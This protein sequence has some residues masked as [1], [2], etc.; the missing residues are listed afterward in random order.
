[1]L[2]GSGVTDV[3]LMAVLAFF[4]DSEGDVAG[5]AAV[6]LRFTI[7]TPIVRRLSVRVCGVGLQMAG[8]RVVFPGFCRMFNLDS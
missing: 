2:T 5:F 8:L 1:V 4:V 3:H 6:T 7:C